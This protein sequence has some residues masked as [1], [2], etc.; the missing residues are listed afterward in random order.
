MVIQVLAQFQTVELSEFLHSLK[1]AIASFRVLYFHYQLLFF[2]APQKKENK[3]VEIRKTVSFISSSMRQHFR[4]ISLSLSL[5]FFSFF[6]FSVILGIEL[7][8]LCSL[9]TLGTCSTTD[10][11]HQADLELSDST[12]G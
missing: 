2:N 7:R 6:I 9:G 10:R 12:S 5:V 1:E 3:T 4:L 8:A 11:G